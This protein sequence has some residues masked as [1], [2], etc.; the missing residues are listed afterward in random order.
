MSHKFFQYRKNSSVTSSSNDPSKPA[1][2]SV[3]PKNMI[4]V[5]TQA[6]ADVHPDV[7]IITLL[8]NNVHAYI[9]FNT[10]AILS[11]ISS[12]FIKKLVSLTVHL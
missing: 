1:G 5:M 10:G 7:I 9:L 3:P 2:V 12:S 11:F 6:E 4:Y 8:V